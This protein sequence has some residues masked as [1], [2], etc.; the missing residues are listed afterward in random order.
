MLLAVTDIYFKHFLRKGSENMSK[1]LVEFQMKSN[2]LVG[3]ESKKENAD[4]WEFNVACGWMGM[5]PV[6]IQEVVT[7][8]PN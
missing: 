1:S 8:I 5:R 3:A 2:C 6:R 4:G 7:S